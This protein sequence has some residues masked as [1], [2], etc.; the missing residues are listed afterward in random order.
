MK[1]IIFLLAIVATVTI[2][3]SCN[4]KSDPAPTATLD[5]P[6][7]PY[8]YKIRNTAANADQKATLGRVL[9]Y[10]KHLSINNAIACASC[11][12]Q[13][14][15]FAD[16]KAFSTG[17]EGKLTGRNSKSI[18]NLGGDNLNNFRID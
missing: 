12:K 10:D 11:H 4:K 6:A 8:D 14:A 5:L 17:F 1:K 15:G 9:F 3:Y 7:T 18:A 2:V 16:T 13:E